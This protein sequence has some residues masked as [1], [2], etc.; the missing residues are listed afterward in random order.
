MQSNKWKFLNYAIPSPVLLDMAAF[1]AQEKTI[2]NSIFVTSTTFSF[3]T[4]LVSI[5]IIFK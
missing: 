5:I 4:L 2:P 3:H 1:R